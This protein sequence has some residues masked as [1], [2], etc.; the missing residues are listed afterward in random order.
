MLPAGR[1]ARRVKGCGVGVVI[2]S[3]GERVQMRA[4]RPETLMSVRAALELEDEHHD[5]AP[6][7]S[8]IR[9]RQ[10]EEP[11]GNNSQSALIQN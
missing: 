7:E 5:S 9:Y 10:A 6:R 8:A 11:K 2:S 1:G 3:L 4:G